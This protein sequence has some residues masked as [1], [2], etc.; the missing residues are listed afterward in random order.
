MRRPFT[1]QRDLWGELSLCEN[2]YANRDP[3]QIALIMQRNF[4]NS[5]LRFCHTYFSLHIAL[6]YHNGYMQYLVLKY[7]EYYIECASDME[8]S[9]LCMCIAIS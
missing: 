4:I 8:L 2:F 7:Y 1:M 9:L 3:V 6:L 5:E